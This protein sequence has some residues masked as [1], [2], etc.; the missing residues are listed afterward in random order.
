M[1]PP[2]VKSHE[3]VIVEDDKVV[4]CS[5]TGM[6]LKELTDVR[7]EV[8]QEM[9]QLPEHLRSRYYFEQ[10]LEVKIQMYFGINDPEK[11]KTV[12]K[13]DPYKVGD[14]LIVTNN[15]RKPVTKR[16]ISKPKKTDAKPTVPE[17]G[18][19]EEE[20]ETHSS[21][22]T[23]SNGEETTPEFEPG[24]DGDRSESE[25][26][27]VQPQAVG[28]GKHDVAEP[29][30][31]VPFETAP[32]VVGGSGPTA[33]VVQPQAV[34]RGRHDIAEPKPAI[35]NETAPDVGGESEPAA[36]VVQP[37]AV[38]RGRCDIAEPKPAIP[39]E[40][41]QE[42]IG[43]SRHDVT[44]NDDVSK[45][46][47][48][49]QVVGGSMRDVSENLESDSAVKKE[50]TEEK[51]DG[52][53]PKPKS[54]SAVKNEETV[55]KTKIAIKPDVH[56]VS[57][58]LKSDSEIKMEETEEKPDGA[59]PKPKS[60]SAVK[61]EETEEKLDGAAPKPES[62]SAVKMRKKPKRGTQWNQ[63]KLRVKLKPKRV[64]YAMK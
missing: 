63:N 23:G 45:D 14:E 53:T 12:S 1:L 38:G 33:P 49:P 60:D 56:D 57:E 20:T 62:D 51:L 13:K 3:E 41:A 61:K 64:M 29:K 24:S 39:N 58:N 7:H 18:E 4:T 16:D 5:I 17:A 9:V 25:A 59:A 46:I 35:P 27:V 32:D 37:Q 8:M 28:R 55:E 21:N 11:L 36:P 30:P 26:P 22:S 50:E 52:A 2:V 15:T 42:V 40:T 10:S 19:S 48:Q 31:T 44:S 54:D 34:G 6:S 47:S 43:G